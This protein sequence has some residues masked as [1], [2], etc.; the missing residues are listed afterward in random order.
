MN[1]RRSMHLFFFFFLFLVRFGGCITL[2]LF[3]VTLTDIKSK[4]FFFFLHEHEN[5]KWL[6]IEEAKKFLPGKSKKKERFSATRGVRNGR[7]ISSQNLITNAYLRSVTSMKCIAT[8]K[9]GIKSEFLRGWFL[10]Q[11]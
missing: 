1:R 9:E 10:P 5:I 4:W 8:W 11:A 3:T 2:Y 6:L 7:L